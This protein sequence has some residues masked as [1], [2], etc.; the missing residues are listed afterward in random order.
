[1]KNKKIKSFIYKAFG[2]PILLIN[3]P[4]KKILGEW[5]I[6]INYNVLEKAVLRSLINKPILL[7]GAEWRFIRK[8]LILTTT[9]FGKIFDVSHAAISKWESEKA[10]PPAAADIY[11]RL[12]LIDHLS[13]KD[14]DFRNL[15]NTI[16]PTTLAKHKG[17]KVG[18]ISINIEEDLKTA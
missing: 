2:F 15:Y 16:S 11:I 10:S 12:F 5:V 14:K 1:M 4:M 13:G 6:D 3:V 18:P 17:K 7:N 9:D 8:S